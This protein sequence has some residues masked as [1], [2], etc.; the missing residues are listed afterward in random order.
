MSGRL[1]IV[2]CTC[3]FTASLT[4]INRAFGQIKEYY[5]TFLDAGRPKELLGIK[6]AVGTF[7]AATLSACKLVMGN[8]LGNIDSEAHVGDFNLDLSG[9]AMAKE[10]LGLE[11][12]VGFAQLFELA[13]EPAG[14]MRHQRLR[15]LVQSGVVHPRK[16]KNNLV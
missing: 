15:H 4:Q 2:N 12:A 10:H 1:I 16:R 14:S 7:A 11:A 9:L 8:M 5:S 6:T 13:W 3:C